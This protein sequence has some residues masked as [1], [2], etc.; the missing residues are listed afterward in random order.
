MRLASS[1]NAFIASPR[2]SYFMGP[3]YLA[4]CHGPDLDGTMIWG[5]P[6]EHDARELVR[7]YLFQR[8]PTVRRDIVTDARHLMSVDTAGFAYI[9]QF[10]AQRHSQ[11]SPRVRR[12]VVLHAGGLAGSAVAGFLATLSVNHDWRAFREVGPALAWLGRS[13]ATD[14]FTRLDAIAAE[15]IAGSP[16]VRALR[17][18]LAERPQRYDLVRAAQA[19]GMSTRA[20][21]RALEAADTTFRTERDRAWTALATRMLAERNDKLDMLARE[22]G[23]RSLASFDRRFVRLVGRT[24]SEHRQLRRVRG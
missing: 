24:P 18:L 3:T 19:L 11:I 23:C 4:W 13:D 14:V 1:P 20:L 21:Q 7:L 12:Q 10:A 5:V 17:D 9:Y 6:N 15:R 22:L 8:D 16:T 2:G